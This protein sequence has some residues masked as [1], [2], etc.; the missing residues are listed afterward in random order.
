[1][2]PCRWGGFQCGFTRAAALA[3]AEPAACAN[4]GGMVRGSR[5]AAA[6]RAHAVSRIRRV[7]LGVHRGQGN[8]AARLQSGVRP[9]RP[10]IQVM[11]GCRSCGAPREY[12]RGRLTFT[13]RHCGTEE[14]VP[15][16]LQAFDLFDASGWRCPSCQSRPVEGCRRRPPHPGVFRAVHG[17]LI[18]MSSF[19]AV[20]AVVRFFEGQTPRRLASPR[21]QTPGDRQIECPG[22]GGPMT[23]HNYGGP[24]NIV[25]D[26]C[27]RCEL[28]WLDPGELRRHRVGTRF[29]A[30]RLRAPDGRNPLAAGRAAVSGKTGCTPVRR[31]PPRTRI[32]RQ[33]LGKPA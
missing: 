4:A 16:G 30:G 14:P 9:D 33:Y 3:S 19:I 15:V 32:A 27:E 31:D 12:D 6:A 11:T 23:S 1:M 22:C 21:Q 10:I 5:L 20:V 7:L 25:M 24:G 8:T 28:N 29:Q 13:C 26:T 2:A 18:A 17:A